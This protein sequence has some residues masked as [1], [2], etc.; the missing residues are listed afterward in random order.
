M[1]IVIAI[2]F[3]ALVALLLYAATKPDT[4]QFARSIHIAAPPERIFPLIDDLRAMNAWN[5]FVKADPNI[6]LAYSG[7]ASGVGA[8]NTFEGNGKVGAGEAEII[9]SVAPA[10]VVMALRMDRPIKCRNRV[11]FTLAPRPNGADVST[12]V[13]WAMSGAQPF[14]GKLMSI[15]INTDKMV[16]GAFEAGLAELKARAEA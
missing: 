13:T 10:K 1:F 14:V 3:A 6:R 9:E 11:E 2:A 16:G 15:L 4:C 7:P 8:V 12:D 5:P